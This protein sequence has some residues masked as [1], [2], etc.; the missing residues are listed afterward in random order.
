MNKNNLDFDAKMIDSLSHLDPPEY[1]ILK[2]NPWSKSIGSIAWGFSLTTLHLNFLYLQYILPTIGTALIF[3]GFRS[4]R[5]ENRYFKTVYIFSIFRLI[6]HLAGLVWISTPLHML[7]YITIPIGTVMFIFQII[8]FVISQAALNE[9]HKKAGKTPEYSPF[10][11]IAAWTAASFFIALSPLSQSW[12]FF[13]PMVTFYILIIRSL[14]RIGN[15]LDNT[16]YVLTN[17]P[18]KINSETFSRVYFVTALMIAIICSIFSNHLR[19]KPQEFYLPEMTPMRHSLINAGFPTEALNHLSE[20]DVEKLIG[21]V[22]IKSISELLMFDPKEIE[23]RT[24][25]GNH[26]SINYTY[27]PGKNNLDVTTIYIEMPE[28][29]IYVMQYFVWKGGSPVWQDGILISGENDV[30][31]KKIVNSGLFYS[32]DGISYE[33]DFPNLACEEVIQNTMFGSSY[34]TPISG[35]LSY[36]FGSKDQ[37]GYVLYSY[38]IPDEVEFYI[39][40]SIF[41][42]MHNSGPLHLPYAR[43]DEKIINGAYLFSD[44]IKQHYTTYESLREKDEL[45]FHINGI[46]PQNR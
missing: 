13:I 12:L 6:L 27:E 17:A 35:T 11:R 31:N 43:T 21:A 3:L 5:N 7:D 24:T 34:T 2:T 37:G 40:F 10:Y 23:H 46:Q 14:F 28:N 39:T 22:N 30:N 33:A 9:A 32:K 16:G 42:Y 19:L 26:T 8:M 20:E 38:E 1:E 4:L 44:K 15:E 25:Y 29:L 18:V 45:N 41:N 36:P